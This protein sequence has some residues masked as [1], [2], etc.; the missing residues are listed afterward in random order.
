LLAIQT[1][2]MTPLI[3]QLSYKNC[4]GYELEGNETWE[5]NQWIENLFFGKH[6]WDGGKRRTKWITL[7][8]FMNTHSFRHYYDEDKEEI[9]M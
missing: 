2:L 8:D 7:L 5:Q 9:T 3:T 6:N 4:F 1:L